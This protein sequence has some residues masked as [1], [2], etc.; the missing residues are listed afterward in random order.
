VLERA[1]ASCYAAETH[2]EALRLLEHDPGFD[3]A[4]LDFDMANRDAG[5]LVRRIRAIRPHLVLVG[6]S[7][8][9]RSAEF[10]A[11]GVHRYLHKPW[12]IGDLLALLNQ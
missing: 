3:L 8:V 1:G 5:D 2:A 11:R 6:T 9:D 4:I 10:V 12:T 7:G